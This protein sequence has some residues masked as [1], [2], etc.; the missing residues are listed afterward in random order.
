MTPLRLLSAVLLLPALALAAG[1]RD[2][3]GQMVRAA[4]GAGVGAPRV[5]PAFYMPP[6]A[7]GCYATGSVIGTHG[8]QATVT[9]ASAATFKDPGADPVACTTE[10]ARYSEVGLRA[11]SARTQAYPTPETPAAATTGSLATG[12]WTFWVEGTG[13][14]QIS[15][16]TATGSGWCTATATA[17][18]AITVTVAGTATL[19]AVTGSLTFAQLES[20]AFRTS[21]ITAASRASETISVPIR[22]PGS[23]WCWAAG[24]WKGHDRAWGS[25]A[26]QGLLSAGTFLG[27]N[28]ASLYVLAGSDMRLEVRDAANAARTIGAST[29]TWPATACLRAC[30]INGTLSLWR[31][32]V[33]TGSSATGAGTGIVATWPTS[34]LVGRA[35][36]SANESNMGFRSVK[37]CK[38]NA[39]ESCDCDLWPGV[40]V[41]DS[42]SNDGGDWAP[43]VA[44]GLGGGT[45]NF[46]NLAVSGYRTNQMVTAWTASG[47]TRRP[48][49]LM[50]LGGANDVIGSVAAPAIQANLEQMMDEQIADGGRVIVLTVLPFKNAA[51][52]TADKE[53]VRDAVNVA[54]LAY[55]AA[56]TQATCVDAATAAD[57][58]T[59]ALKAAWDSGDGLHP[60]ATGGAAIA[61][62]VEAAGFPR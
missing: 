13:S 5:S 20:G 11:E 35:S 39:P 22:N 6:L 25:G 17:P 48:R 51:G 1:A 31:D 18:C 10:Q 58:G 40:I 50:L 37:M 9:R 21:R 27:A 38:T 61:D 32:G 44:V 42:M 28:S 41:G 57:D 24:V 56:H 54:I 62:L 7:L 29:G 46:T 8:N 52:Y 55:C 60:N 30:S 36:A 49:V 53:I 45:Y 23:A 59:G 19:A 34:M 47:R 14:Q 33:S 12:T 15:A 16:G 4:P 26:T 43:I 3:P 2:Q